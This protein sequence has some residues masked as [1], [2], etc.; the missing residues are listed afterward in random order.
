[1]T[2]GQLLANITSYELSEWMAFYSIEPFGEVRAD[3]RAAMIACYVAA[4]A[5]AKDVKLEDFMLNFDPPKQM[6]ADEIKGVL[7][8]L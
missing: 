7:R 3:R 1:M 8:R 4:S 6:S 2:A 5:G